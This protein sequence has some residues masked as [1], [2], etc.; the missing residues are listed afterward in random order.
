MQKKKNHTIIYLV[1]LQSTKLL[2][3]YS[4]EFVL[5]KD[6][7]SHNITQSGDAFPSKIVK[8]Q[9]RAK[10]LENFSHD[11]TELSKHVVQ[12]LFFIILSNLERTLRFLVFLLF[13][14]NIQLAAKENRTT[15]F[16]ARRAVSI[17]PLKKKKKGVRSKRKAHDGVFSVPKDRRN[18]QPF[19]QR[20]LSRYFSNLQP[21]RM[22]DL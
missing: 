19:T 12:F 21:G 17:V 3:Y 7:S 4:H 2:L 13:N 10:T 9:T 8:I 22:F 20:H 15:S 11:W 6:D 1:S 5:F 16:N 14:P 18:A